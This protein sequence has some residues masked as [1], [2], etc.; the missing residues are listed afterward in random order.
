MG[1]MEH[2]VPVSLAVLLLIFLVWLSNKKLSEIQ[3]NKVFKAMGFVVCGFVVVY[4]FI[5]FESG[6]DIAEDLPLF[7]CG[8]MGLIIPFFTTTRKYWMF[9]ILVFW[10]LAGTIQSVI[11]PDID[12]AFP[13]FNFIR[14]WVVHLGLI[15]IMLYA[16]FVFK[17]KPTLKS[18]FKS[19]GALQI[20]VVSMFLINYL[21]GS[22]YFYLNRK[23]EATT[24]LDLFGDWPI[25]LLVTELIILPFFFLI[26]FLFNL[27]VKPISQK[28]ETNP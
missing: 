22:N 11:T 8:L 7:L 1:S 17:M 18:V 6:Y 24:L 26:Y 25:Y 9:E 13:T 27:R 19:F 21:L 3:K 2:L 23:P 20:Y 15:M 14:Y 16:F 5:K 10:V 12:E 4:Q 28:A